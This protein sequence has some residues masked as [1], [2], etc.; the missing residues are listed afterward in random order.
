VARGR[1]A[2]ATHAVPETSYPILRRL[3]F[4]D[5]CTLRRLEDAA[6]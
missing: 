2:L 1:P 3:G 5:A 4:E 6:R